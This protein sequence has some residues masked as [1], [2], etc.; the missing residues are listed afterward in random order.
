MNDNK[1]FNRGE[2]ANA[3]VP[4]NVTKMNAISN[5]QMLSYVQTMSFIMQIYTIII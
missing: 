4:A 5:A 1:Q 3:T 2:L